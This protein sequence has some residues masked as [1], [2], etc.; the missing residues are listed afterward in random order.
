MGRRK[1]TVEFK[2][3]LVV[4]AMRGDG[5]LQTIAARQGLNPTQLGERK[6]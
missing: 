3:K 4:Q 2:R 6:T 5:T 1:F